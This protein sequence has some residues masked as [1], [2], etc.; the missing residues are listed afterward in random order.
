MSLRTLL[1]YGLWTV[2]G[3]VVLY[4]VKDAVVLLLS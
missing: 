3:L 1:K 4:L 2:G